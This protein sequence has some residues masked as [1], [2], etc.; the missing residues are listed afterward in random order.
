MIKESTKITFPSGSVFDKS[1]IIH[2]ENKENEI[3]KKILCYY[4]ENPLWINKKK[5]KKIIGDYPNFNELSLNKQEKIIE[6][7]S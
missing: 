5:Y 4:R 2:F 3:I 1:T 6:R 7:Y